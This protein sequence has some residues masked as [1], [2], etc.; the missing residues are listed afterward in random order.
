MSPIR[1]A[2]RRSPLALAQARAVADWLRQSV[3]NRD[4]ELVA[5]TTRGDVDL[6]ASLRMSGGKGAFIEALEEALLADRAD[7]AVHS[8]KDVPVSV[9]EPFAL[10]PFGP[11]ADARDALVA[12]DGVRAISDLAPGATVGTASPRRRALLKSLFRDLRVVPARGNVGTRLQRL[13][14]GG[15]DALLLACAGLHRLDLKQ[16]ISQCFDPQV[17]VPAPGQGV[18]AVQYLR[19]RR[20]E[21]AVLRR[22]VD[23]EVRR[24]V[25][26]ERRLASRLG[27]DCGLPLGAY[28]VAEGAALRLVAVAADLEG[29]RVLRIVSHGDDP[30][31]LGDD[32]ARRLEALGV[33]DLLDH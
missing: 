12:K 14:E 15:F 13:D 1:I 24:C 22:G 2:T 31:A 3:P 8:M 17:L 30:V 26:T 28:C 9:G 10:T 32:A 33:G 23:Q 4:V 5:I 11:R 25:A 27:A 20:D 21:L 18:L 7:L 6:S 29:E 19:E 16:R